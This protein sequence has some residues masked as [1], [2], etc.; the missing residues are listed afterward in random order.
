MI[1]SCKDPNKENLQIDIP[2]LDPRVVEIRYILVDTQYSYLW[3][4][5]S[6][7]ETLNIMQKFIESRGSP[8][9]IQHKGNGDPEKCVQCFRGFKAIQDATH[10]F[11]SIMVY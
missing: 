4:C 2:Y 1:K 7:E 10:L 5:T 6:N 11:L 8:E 9:I 3:E